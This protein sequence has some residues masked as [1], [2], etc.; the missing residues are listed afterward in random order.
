MELIGYALGA[1][2]VVA[3]IIFAFVILVKLFTNYVIS[4]LI[5]IALSIAAIAVALIAGN[6]VYTKLTPMIILSAIAWLFFI[7]PVVFQVHYDGSIDWERKGE[8][9]W[10]STPRTT[11]GFIANCIG[12]FVFFSCAY[13]MLGEDYPAIFFFFPLAFLIMDLLM[14][15]PVIKSWFKS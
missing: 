2:A 13:V 11:G 9:H 8:G 4:R 5:S 1:I 6:E 12:A 10:V 3:A 14:M 15:I 7:G